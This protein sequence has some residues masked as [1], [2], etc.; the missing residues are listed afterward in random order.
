MNDASAGNL[1]PL[2]D[3]DVGVHAGTRSQHD[4]I[5]ERR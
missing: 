3:R 5:F 4:E 2:A 1:R